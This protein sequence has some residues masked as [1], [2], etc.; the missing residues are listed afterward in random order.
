MIPNKF[1]ANHSKENVK[2]KMLLQMPQRE[3]LI[4]KN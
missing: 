4:T 2:L 1:I 3:T